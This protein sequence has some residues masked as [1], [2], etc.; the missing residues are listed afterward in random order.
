MIPA[1]YSVIRHIR[2][3]FRAVVNTNDLPRFALDSYNRDINSEITRKNA[4]IER[5]QNR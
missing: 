3:A 4:E 5:N 2:N 1:N